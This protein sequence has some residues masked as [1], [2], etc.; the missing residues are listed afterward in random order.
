LA[1]NEEKRI[2]WEEAF[3]HSLIPEEKISI[4]AV[5]TTKIKSQKVMKSFTENRSA[6][7]VKECLKGLEEN[8]PN[9]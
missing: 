1:I 3:E 9:S 4:T 2:S 7:T 5:L 6:I 8:N